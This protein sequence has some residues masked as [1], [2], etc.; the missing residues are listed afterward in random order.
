[1]MKSAQALL[2]TSVAVVAIAACM[3]P[4]SARPFNDPRSDRNE[5]IDA[6][7]AFAAEPRDPACTAAA[8]VST[9][10]QAPRNPHTLA[11]RWTGYSNFE[12][13]YNGKIV[14]LDAY[15]IVATSF[16]RSASRRPTSR[17]PTSS[18]SGTGISII[19]RTRPR[20]VR[21]PGPP[22]SARR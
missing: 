21:A 16:P 20:S 12:L 18:C 11:V 4:G 2:T 14:L 3:G 9:G 17:R 7:P 19:C 22:S 6:N 1:M 13:A 15:T 5:A 10:G 8:L